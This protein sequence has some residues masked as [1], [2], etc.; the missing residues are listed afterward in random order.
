ME[1]EV[2]ISRRFGNVIAIIKGAF[3]GGAQHAPIITVT[4]LPL[5]TEHFIL[6]TE[7][8]FGSV[9]ATLVTHY[10]RMYDVI[11]DYL[12]NEHGKY[13]IVSRQKFV[14]MRVMCYLD[15]RFGRGA[16]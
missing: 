5:S 14:C 1:R 6:K 13:F 4:K 11:D 8:V 3:M 16:V 12:H 9:L 7:P 10:R 15:R 2:E